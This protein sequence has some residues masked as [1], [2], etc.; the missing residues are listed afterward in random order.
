M[1]TQ[2]TFSI[3]WTPMPSSHF[4][5]VDSV[6]TGSYGEVTLSPKR[7]IE[8]FWNNAYK[9]ICDSELSWEEKDSQNTPHITK[10]M[11]PINL[12]Y[13]FV[14]EHFHFEDLRDTGDRYFEHL[15]RTAYNIMEKTKNP[16]RLKILIALLH[17]VIENTNFIGFSDISNMFHDKTLWKKVALWVLL[18][19]KDP[20]I[21]YIKKNQDHSSKK[22]YDALVSFSNR[23]VKEKW[24]AF[25]I[26]NEKGFLTREFRLRR[27]KWE[28]TKKENEWFHKYASFKKKYSKQM[29]EDYYPRFSSTKTMKTLAQTY[30]SR[31]ELSLDND[32]IAEVVEAAL[33][34]KD[35]DRL[36]NLETEAV[37]SNGKIRKKIEEY[38]RTFRPRIEREKPYLLE[39]MDKAVE[40][41]EKVIKNRPIEERV[42]KIVTS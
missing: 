37:S 31:N 33:D 41:L 7:W 15:V 40:K 6:I 5:A 29:S 4:V 42:H 24:E 20:V 19:T 36:D 21:K 13:A 22:S 23:Q 26:I 38:K 17:D 16:S 34:S 9:S 28:L 11:Q 8:E 10:Y 32:E 14:K 2:A 3:H 12:A 25:C 35:A 27:K 18:L 39:H 1:N 30:S